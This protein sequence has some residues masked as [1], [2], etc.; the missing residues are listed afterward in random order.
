MSDPSFCVVFGADPE[1]LAVER[2][3]TSA[4]GVRGSQEGLAEF[5]FFFFGPFSSCIGAEG[6]YNTLFRWN[7]QVLMEDVQEF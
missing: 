2:P 1:S 7:V 5:F 6:S 3:V 4:S